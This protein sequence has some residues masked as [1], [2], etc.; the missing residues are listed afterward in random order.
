MHDRVPAVN[1]EQRNGHA[2]QD[3]SQD[4]FGHQSHPGRPVAGDEGA[5]QG[6]HH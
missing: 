2:V 4:Q 6:Y 1:H 3:A 5:Q